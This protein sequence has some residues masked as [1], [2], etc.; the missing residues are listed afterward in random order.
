MLN[1]RKQIGILIISLGLLI[2][3]VI[4]YFIFR[5]PTATTP[6]SSVNPS[7]QSGPNLPATPTA[8]TT[9]PSSLV[10]NKQFDISKEKPHVIGLADLAKRAMLYSERF[11]SYS[12]QSDYGNFSDLKIF[13]TPGLR[14]WTDKY[15]NDLKKN[16]SSSAGYY[17]IETKALT[18][19]AKSFDDKAGTANITVT[20][21]RR[22]SREQIGG[23]DPY[24]QK[25][26]FTFV[27]SGNDWLIDKIYWQKK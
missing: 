23:G 20:T 1:N 10:S 19:E 3:L 21:Q 8:G 2:L 7:N 5:Q 17:G 27:K 9:T 4:L 15:I 13:M 6:S 22:E 16:A 12:N 25:I 14:T 26:D 18:T 24:L 11:G